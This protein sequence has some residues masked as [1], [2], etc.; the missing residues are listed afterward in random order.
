VDEEGNTTTQDVAPL[1]MKYCQWDDT[2]HWRLSKKR[3]A[4]LASVPALVPSSSAAGYKTEFGSFKER[5]NGMGTF[6]TP[7]V[8]DSCLSMI[9]EWVLDLRPA[10][11]KKIF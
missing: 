8:R 7:E 5:I 11:E 6:T 10:L 3:L 4:Q 9:P 2:T 1:A